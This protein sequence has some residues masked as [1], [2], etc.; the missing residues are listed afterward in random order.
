MHSEENFALAR[1][2]MED[3]ETHD[4]CAKPG[5]GVVP[6]RLLEINDSRVRLRPSVPGET[7]KWTALSYCWGGPQPMQ[8]TTDI[9][10]ERM[11]D[12]PILLLPQTIKDAITTT[13]EIGLSY[14]WVDC[15]CI[16]QDDVDD[17]RREI[18]MMPRIYRNASV[19]ISAARAKTSN[20]GFLQDVSK[21]PPQDISF[22][23]RFLCPDGQIGSLV[24]YGQDG[25]SS[26]SDSF[27]LRL[28]LQVDYLFVITRFPRR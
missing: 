8:T 14:L 11:E 1:K 18:S 12:I 13:R 24:F 17:V 27:L 19:T 10:A 7:L 3:C 26:F 28:V 6:T 21:I 25:M 20:E 15:L 22:R 2:W 16:I 9:L 5:P 4:G 23:L